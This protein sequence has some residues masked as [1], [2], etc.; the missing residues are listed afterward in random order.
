MTVLSE[1]TVKYK[2]TIGF[3]LV[4]VLFV[5]FGV[6]S[7][8]EVHKLG[9]LTKMIYEHPLVVSNAALNAAINMTKMHRTMKDVALSNSPDEFDKASNEVNK[10]EQLVYA[11]LDVVR[12]MIIG[13]EGQNLEKRT[14]KLFADWKP[15]REEVFTL[16]D[17]GR[18]NEAALITKGK[19]ADHVAK[20]EEKMLELTSYA[21]KKADGFM[22]LA[23]K[24]QSKV[25]NITTILVFGGVFLSA[26]IAFFT[27]RH[28]LKVEKA[29]LNERNELQ[30]ALS[31]IKTLSGLLPICASCKKIRDDKGYWNQIELYIRDHTEAEF[32]HS[33]CPI[34]AEKLYGDLLK[35]HN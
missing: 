18:R 10:L 22:Q 31:K 23:E 27:V 34:C 26:F 16:F 13:T 32:S 25:E 12:E 4:I 29:L 24:S 19:G 6:I 2:L 8:W 30:K 1:K 5:S 35:E 21:R 20:L 11:K 14:R 17:S 7:L 3:L 9:S 15:I 33:L 28:V